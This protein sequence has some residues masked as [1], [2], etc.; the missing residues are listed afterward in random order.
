MALEP[1]LQDVAGD[2]EVGLAVGVAA[3]VAVLGASTRGADPTGAF[4][5]G[6]T[7]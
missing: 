2:P 7:H 3:L 4:Q 1:S 6:W 5:R